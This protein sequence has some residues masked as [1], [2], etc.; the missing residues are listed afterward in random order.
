[1]RILSVYV[2][3][4]ARLLFNTKVPVR[5]VLC[6]VNVALL[7]VISTTDART[8]DPVELYKVGIT[9]TDTA[10]VEDSVY[11]NT[12]CVVGELDV[13]LLRSPYTKLGQLTQLITLQQA[14]STSCFVVNTSAYRLT[15]P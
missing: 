9:S 10:G 11:E 4:V 13:Y 2:S 3:V 7:G 15:S 6:L 12:N 8:T 5:L 14:V 1:M